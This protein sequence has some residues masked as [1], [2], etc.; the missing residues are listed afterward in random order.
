MKDESRQQ[1]AAA[2]SSFILHPSSFILFFGAVMNRTLWLLLGLQ[3]RGWMRYLARGAST[4]RGLILL[5]VGLGV[6]LPWLFAVLTGPGVGQVGRERL[7]DYGPATLLLYCLVNVLFTPSER[8]VYFTPAEVQFLFAG[9]FT[10]RQVLVYKI[11]LSLLVSVPATM[12]LGAIVRVRD[13][14]L[15]AVLLGLF[16][17]SSF[18]QLFTMALG[19]LANALGARLYSHGRRALAVVGA[20]LLGLLVL[21][22]GRRA[23]WQWRAVGEQV[24]ATAVWRTVS[25]P[26]QSFFVALGS[27]GFADLAVPLLVGLGVNGALVVVIL[28]LEHSYQE[29]S[30][31][32]SARRY[33]A[34]R[35]RRGHSAG[36]EPPG[37]ARAARFALPALPWWGGIGPVLWRQLTS[38]FRGLGRLVFVFVLICVVLA[39]AVGGTL[40][41]AVAESPTKLLPALFVVAWV[42][43]FMTALV[44]FDFRGDLDRIAMLKTL[45]VLPWRLALGQLLTPVLLLSVFQWLTLALLWALAPE[46]GMLVAGLTAFVPP[47][48][49]VLV[50]LDNLLFLLFPVRIA[51]ATPG[52][53]Q[54]LGRNVLLSIGKLIGMLVVIAC[55][56]VVSGLAYALTQ[57]YWL[58]VA[59]AWPVLVVCGAGLVPLVALAFVWFDVG[60]DTPA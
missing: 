1:T 18:M 19:L 36:A 45:P 10:R 26:L 43:V 5:L 12:F 29:A 17:I 6:F 59:A 40:A 23:G 51:A 47:F 28:A 44:P 21:E 13:G 39:F 3:M 31:A 49:F 8:A 27:R 55:A 60:R 50:A 22:A 2:F 38:A 37:G 9:P 32:A 46:E 11:V 33:A 34:L 24:A 15:P 56:S 14:W 58:A 52:D 53:F 7:V 30:A 16:L 25:W 57:S 54:A 42:S 4:V 48:N 35:R 20:V 41:E